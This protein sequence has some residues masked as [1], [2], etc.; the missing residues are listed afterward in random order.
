MLNVVALRVG[1]VLDHIKPG[2]AMTIFHDLKL[3]KLDF[4]FSIIYNAK[5]NK[6]CK[7]DI[8]QVECPI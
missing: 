2:N 5:S 6:M 3:Y 1:F 8:I 4:T 7:K